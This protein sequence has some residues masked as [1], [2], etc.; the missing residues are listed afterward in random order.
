MHFI[1]FYFYFWLFCTA[2]RTLV[3]WPGIK[4]WPKA[5]EVQNPTHWITRQL[6]CNTFYKNFSITCHP[7]TIPQQNKQTNPVAFISTIYQLTFYVRRNFWKYFFKCQCIHI[8][9]LRHPWLQPIIKAH[10]D[11]EGGGREVQDGGHMYTHGW[12]MSMYGKN[13]YNIVK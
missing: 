2:C 1:I 3:P 9:F 5:V 7:S 13:H 4:P 11:R 10:T 12:F 6:P 8:K